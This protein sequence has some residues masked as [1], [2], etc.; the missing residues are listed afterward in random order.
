MNVSEAHHGQAADGQAAG[1][2]LEEA[3]HP[4]RGPGRHSLPRSID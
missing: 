4:R 1:S 3:K 2:N